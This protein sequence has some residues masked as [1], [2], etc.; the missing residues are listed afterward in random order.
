MMERFSRYLIALCLGLVTMLPCSGQAYLKTL[1]PQGDSAVIAKMRYKMDRIRK[2]RPTVAVVLSGGGA[3]GAA[4]VGALKYLEEQGIPVDMVLGTSMGGLIGGLYSIGYSPAFMDSLLRSVD[5]NLIL[6]D[7]IPTELMPYQ[8]RKY[9]EQYL[10][11]IPFYYSKKGIM[12]R[13]TEDRAGAEDDGLL[14]L[15]AGDDLADRNLK[16]NLFGSLPSGY[17]FGQNVNNVFSGLTVGYQDDIDFSELPIPFFCIAG[18]MVSGKAKLWSSGKLN[19]ALRSTMSIPGIFAPVR[20][21]SLVLVD[22]GIRNNYPTDIAREMGADI[23]IGSELSDIDKTYSD[24]N[25]IADML[26]Q[27]IDIL[28]RDSFEKNV[29]IPDVTIKPDLT[30]FNMLSFDPTSVDTIISRGYQAALAQADGIKEIKRRV[31]P[32]TIE[33]QNPPAVDIGEIPIVLSGIQFEGVTPAEI[34]YLLKKIDVKVWDKVYKKDIEDAVATIFSTKSFDYVNYELLRDDQTYILVFK[35]KKGPVHQVGAGVRID[36]ETMVS[37]LVNVGFNVHRVEGSSW[38]FIGKIGSNPYLDINYTFRMAGTPAFHMD[39]R[40]AHTDVNLYSIG[41]APRFNIK[42]TQ[43]SQKFYLSDISWRKA[44]I[45]VGVRNDYFNVSSLLSADYIPQEYDTMALKNDYVTVFAEARTDTFDDG[46][47]PSKGTNAGVTFNYL[48]GGLMSE[49]P[50]TYIV[51]LDASKVIRLGRHLDFIP[52]L[53]SRCALG[54]T[55]LPLAFMNVAGGSM[56][57]RYIEQQ[58]PFI[59]VSYATPLSN[60]MLMLRGDLR[61]RL[62]EN[63]YLS[64]IANVLKDSDAF[65]TD[66]LWTGD[67]IFGCGIQYGYDSSFGPIKADIHWSNLTRSIGAYL[68]IGFDF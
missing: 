28:G 53:Y 56:A 42:Y 41:T 22:G 30:G 7:R 5:W 67:N 61:I 51:Q 13:R 19:T 24:I 38:D 57:G 60:K 4:H 52:T 54:S 59:G 17:I 47:F 40:N 18:E 44:N 64:L 66:L 55:T 37:A 58:Q 23:I 36:S 33:F 11:S 1:D 16:E 32:D 50:Q 10:L 65:D 26:W 46:Y 9:K 14:H 62:S 6:S 21:D 68:G 39:L 8:Q 63:N 29:S 25:N 27:F 48:L 20:T 43:L 15:G 2:E 12:A 35:C 49:V 45:K 31:G 34:D 3:K